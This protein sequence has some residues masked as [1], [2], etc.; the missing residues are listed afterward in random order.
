MSARW[1]IIGV[2]ALSS[3]GG[4]ADEMFGNLCAGRSGRAVLRGFHQDWYTAREL[5]EVDDRADGADRPLR[6]TGFLVDAIAQALDDAGLSQDLGDTPVLVGTGLREL[7]SVELWRR[8]GAIVTAADLHFGT[9]LRDRF[10]AVSTYTFSNA[11]SASLYALSLATDMLAAGAADTVVVAGT[12]AIT[13]SMFGISDRVQ[14]VPPDALRPFDVDRK[15]TILG[16]GA[17]AIVLRREQR[18]RTSV[19]GWVRG[20]GVNCDA[21][22]PTAP[23]PTRVADAMREA[24][25]RAD[26]TPADI[27][28]VMLHGTGTPANDLGEA[29][30]LREVYGNDVKVPLMTA[31]KAMTGHT[32]GASGLHGLIT[33]LQCA[34]T[35]RVVPTV[36]LDDPMAE[37]AEFRVVSGGAAAEAV[38]LAQVNAFGFGGIN[39]VAVVEGVS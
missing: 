10:G 26:V 16:E 14:S 36:P 20:V 17:A 35:G 8:D 1:P 23:D 19:R 21:S 12:D 13:E 5:Y 6:A 30:A 32:S 28:L 24:H 25:L 11:C 39:A 34:H 31:I 37:I 33:A 38:S 27:D 7:R 22:H 9:A 2:G 29:Q 18:D 4:T 3:V 15:G